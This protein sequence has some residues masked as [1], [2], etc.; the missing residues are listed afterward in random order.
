MFRDNSVTGNSAD[1]G[2]G[3]Y[4]YQSDAT[5]TNDVLS[6]NQ[7]DIAGSGLYVEGASPRLLHATISHNNGGD[8]SGIHVT[9]LISGSQVVPSH[10][11]LTNTILVRHSVGITVSPGNAAT[12]NGVLWY[13]NGAN[14]AGAGTVTLDNAVTGDPAFAPDGF[15]LTADSA[16]LDAGIDGALPTD[17][18]GDERPQGAAPDLGAD[19]IIVVAS[20]LSPDTETSLVYTDTQGLTTTLQVPLGAVTET[21]RLVFIPTAVTAPPGLTS[22]GHGFDLAAYRQG[23]Q[24]PGFTFNRPLTLT[25]R[26]SDRDVRLV[27]DERQLF[28]AWWTGDEWVDA[29]GT[30]DPSGTATLE[31]YLDP[32]RNLLRLP[33]CHLSRFALF[34]PTRQMYLP[35]VLRD[36]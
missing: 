34:G 35:L 9:Q 30:C 4:L 17:I 7:A 26:Y 21:T 1:F 10:P 36:A 20:D 2:G 27:T 18:D 33:I 6:D 19:E 24:L 3:L 32:A 15:H 14:T 16:A 31:I 25:I 12:L 23:V 29:F 11:A 13:G 5:L 8:G 28:L 22:A